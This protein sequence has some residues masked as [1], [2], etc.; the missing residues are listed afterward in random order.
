MVTTPP[1]EQ[2][3]GKNTNQD[4]QFKAWNLT[5]GQRNT[6]TMAGGLSFQHLLFSRSCFLEWGED[7]KKFGIKSEGWFD[8]EHLCRWG[9]Q[10]RPYV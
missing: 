7:G 8:N 1:P 9:R 6:F 3:E 2:S 4:N 5:E 10:N